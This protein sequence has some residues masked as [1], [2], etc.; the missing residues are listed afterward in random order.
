MLRVT[1]REPPSAKLQELIKDLQPRLRNVDVEDIRSAHAMSGWSAAIFTWKNPRIY[2]PEKEETK[3]HEI[4]YILYILFKEN[5]LF[6]KMF[7]EG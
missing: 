1:P 3:G 4:T 5:T 6:S 2:P 7:F